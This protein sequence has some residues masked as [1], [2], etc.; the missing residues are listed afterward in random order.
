[1]SALRVAG[2]ATNVRWTP[3]VATP[4]ARRTKLAIPLLVVLGLV[5]IQIIQLIIGVF[6][7]QGAYELAQL[8]A[9]KHELGTTSEILASEVDSLSSQQN[10]ANAAEGLGMVAN[11]NPVFLRIE[12][13]KIFGK[14]KAAYG[15]DSTK[16]ARNLV[17][18]S[19][20]VST[21]DV[22][23]LKAQQAANAAAAKAAA[24]AKKSAA[25]VPA[26]PVQTNVVPMQNANAQVAFSNGGILASPTH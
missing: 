20:L 22:V 9:Y 1:M 14:P 5:A 2:P 26:G 8:K 3:K 19:M 4:S 25:S 21:T 18:N 15:G 10:L 11:T 7:S 6:I 13:Q 23:A 16:V 24:A 12:D 17:P